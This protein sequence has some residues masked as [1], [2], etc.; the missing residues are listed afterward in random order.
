MLKFVELQLGQRWVAEPNA[1][2]PQVS[3]EVSSVNVRFRSYRPVRDTKPTGILRALS[4]FSKTSPK[5]DETWGTLRLLV[6]AAGAGTAPMIM[7]G[8]R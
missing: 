8:I 3:V 1:P 6:A 4:L 5:L 7:N 2:E